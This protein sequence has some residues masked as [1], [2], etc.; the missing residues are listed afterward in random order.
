MLDEGINVWHQ[1]G[2]PVVAAPGVT[3]PPKEPVGSA[4][5]IR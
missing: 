1:K 3:A 2:Y 4:G 5:Q